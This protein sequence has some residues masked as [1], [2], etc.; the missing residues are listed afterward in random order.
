MCALCVWLHPECMP[1]IMN[2]WNNI[3]RGVGRAARASRCSAAA[4]CVCTSNK[5]P[6]LLSP[7]QRTYKY[8]VQSARNHVIFICTHVPVFRTRRWTKHKA[9]SDRKMHVHAGDDRQ[10]NVRILSTSVHMRFKL[11]M[12]WENSGRKVQTECLLYWNFDSRVHLV[13]SEW[14]ESSNCVVLSSYFLA[15]NY[16]M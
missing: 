10:I 2:A 11:L 3:M 5:H 15:K 9:P 14:N 1:E 4:R 16:F 12:G 13:P 6:C 7:V 8:F